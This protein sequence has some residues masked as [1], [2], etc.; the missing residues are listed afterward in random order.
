MAITGGCQCG[1]I[2]YEL[3]GPPD[4]VSICHCRDC[5]L[6]AGA[7]MVSWALMPTERLTVTK[8]A[9]AAYRSSRDAVRSFC[10]VCGTGLFYTN[11]AMMPHRIDL[12]SVTLDDPSVFA[13]VNRVQT[14]EQPIWMAHFDALPVHRRFPGTD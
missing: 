7:P 14:A 3:S 2:R 11:P 9:P 6:S 8:G 12:Q 1:A 4:R 5:Q 10:P 13:P